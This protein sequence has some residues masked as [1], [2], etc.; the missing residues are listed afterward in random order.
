MILTAIVRFVKHVSRLFK[1]VHKPSLPRI[2]IPKPA[3]PKAPKVNTHFLKRIAASAMHV[4]KVSFSGIGRGFKRFFRFVTAR[5]IATEK[6]KWYHLSPR[7]FTTL[8][9]III[10]PELLLQVAA[11]TVWF[12][13]RLD[14][15]PSILC[16]ADYET[17]YPSRL[18][19]EIDGAKLDW[20]V[21]EEINPSITIATAQKIIDS[22][23]KTRKPSFVYLSVGMNQIRPIQT[24]GARFVWDDSFEW[25]W[26]TP[27]LGHLLATGNP[28]SAIGSQRFR[29]ST[30]QG[31][32]AGQRARVS[33]PLS[34]STATVEPAKNPE[35]ES[36]DVPITKSSETQTKVSESAPQPEVYDSPK[37]KQLLAM[38]Y[39]EQASQFPTGEWS[40][41]CLSMNFSKDGKVLFGNRPMKWTVEGKRLRI[42][43]GLER[44]LEFWWHMDGERLVLVTDWSPMAMV[45]KKGETTSAQ[46]RPAAFFAS[47]RGWSK[48]ASGDNADAEEMLNEADHTCTTDPAIRAMRARLY[49][50]T[51]RSEKSKKEIDWLKDYYKKAPDQRSAESLLYSIT[52]ESDE[53][54]AKTAIDLLTQYPFS[55]RLWATVGEYAGRAGNESVS[56]D[57]IEH[58][59][60]LLPDYLE[61]TRMI[62]LRNSRIRMNPGR[63]SFGEIGMPALNQTQ[64]PQ[65]EEL[66]KTVQDELLRLLKEI[67]EKKP[68]IVLVPYPDMRMMNGVMMEIARSE[69]TAM[70]D[71]RKLPAESRE[72]QSKNRPYQNLKSPETIQKESETIAK[73]V[74]DDFRIRLPQIKNS[75][76]RQP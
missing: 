9:L 57:A 33:L 31:L 25:K 59:L 26:R 76:V 7:L 4:P 71:A 49:G 39:Q 17:S 11:L 60:K 68:Q 48:L 65:V 45:M 8:A 51:E 62:I 3:G 6:A 58:A 46:K 20:K 47:G 70:V 75:S 32:P 64:S 15:S 37:L 63:G 73:L 23:R 50:K 2:H 19:E 16:I 28:D 27:E 74:L 67:P 29:P 21:I 14:K 22:Y 35:T 40:S 10:V 61:R 55:V 30:V 34:N 52:E 13:P 38:Q 66:R 56:R 18:Q 12:Y 36:K 5:R 69:H 42:E 24:G 41:E 53:Q 1:G 43:T 72:L 54:K 44:P